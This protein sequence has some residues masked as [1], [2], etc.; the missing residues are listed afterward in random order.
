M[1]TDL[2]CICKDFKGFGDRMEFNKINFVKK[3]KEMSQERN[4]RVGMPY[5]D[6]FDRTGRL[7][8]TFMCTLA[9]TFHRAEYKEKQIS[10]CPFRLVYKATEATEVN[11]FELTGGEPGHNHKLEGGREVDRALYL[12]NIFKLLTLDT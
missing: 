11:A 8:L 10:G 1:D 2:N 9:H 12:D 7:Q 5:A 6:R 4:F 3:I